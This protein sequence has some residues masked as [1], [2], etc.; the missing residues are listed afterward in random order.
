MRFNLS[1]QP[2]IKHQR[3]TIMKSTAAALI[4]LTVFA[5]T[6]CTEILASGSTVCE[7]KEG[8]IAAQA[9]LDAGDAK[10]YNEIVSSGKCYVVNGDQMIAAT[11][12]CGPI[13]RKIIMNGNPLWCFARNIR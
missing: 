13:T 4:M 5:S 9:A 8:I 1:R 12:C 7:S 6:A 10:K 11:S 2:D 3:G